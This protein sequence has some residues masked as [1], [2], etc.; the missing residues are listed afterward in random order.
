LKKYATGQGLGIGKQGNEQEARLKEGGK[1]SL[2][3][4][5]GVGIGPQQADLEQK[6]SVKGNA[7]RRNT[8][9]IPSIRF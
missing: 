6:K 3:I 2:D 5:G 8:V 7:N 4:R 9:V 1:E